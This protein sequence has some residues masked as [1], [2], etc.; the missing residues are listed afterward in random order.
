MVK[1]LLAQ[2]DETSS[3]GCSVKADVEVKDGV[4]QMS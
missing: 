1:K 3:V 4:F 2:R